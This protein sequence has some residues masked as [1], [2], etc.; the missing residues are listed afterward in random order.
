[1][2]QKAEVFLMFLAY[3]GLIWLS[4]LF[5]SIGIMCRNWLV[6]MKGCILSLCFTLVSVC[7]HVCRYIYTEILMYFIGSN[8]WNPIEGVIK[9]II[10]LHNYLSK[11]SEFWILKH[12]RPEAF[13]KKA[14]RPVL[15]F[16]L[17]L[18]LFHD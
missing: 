9:Y 5:S 2:S 16:L 1:M 4:I 3:Q 14:C 8:T 18:I 12:I 15:G 7:V 10:Y 6:L 11:S 17:F 13:L